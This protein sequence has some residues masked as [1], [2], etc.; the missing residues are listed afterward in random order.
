[1]KYNQPLLLV[2]ITLCFVTKSFA[3][4]GNYRITNGFSISGG[5]TQFD[6]VTDNFTTKS[7][8]G[9][10]GGMAATVDIPN[11]WY[12]V[13]F[14]MQLSENHLEVLGRPD[15]IS[16][17]TT[18]IDYK[19]FA[20]QVALLMQIKVVPQYFTI[21]LG[22]MLQYNGKLELNDRSQENYYI[23]N[24]LNL[25]ANDIKNISQFNFNG[26]VGASVGVKNFK[27]KAQYIY[28]FTNILKK[29]E[30]QPLDF[31]GGNS[32]FEGNQTMLVLGAEISF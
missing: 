28:G 30:K 32:R 5:I 29:I 6:I 9:F 20:A 7:T 13:S 11:R 8:Q 21:D 18:Y 25:S 14:G 26:V 16:N 1:M 12:N 22:P 15:L 17:E 3:Q 4:K 27:L 23:N 24:Y 10:T 31:S 19:M 2:V